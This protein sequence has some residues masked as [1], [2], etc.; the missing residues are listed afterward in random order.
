MLAS[1]EVMSARWQNKSFQGSLSHRNINVNNYS[2]MKIPSQELRNP[3]KRLQYLGG[4][5]K[6]K[7]TY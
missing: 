6:Q 5:W 1:Q 7:E 3:G 2:C 4:T